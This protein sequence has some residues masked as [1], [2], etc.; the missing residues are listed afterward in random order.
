[1]KRGV[2]PAHPIRRPGVWSEFVAF[3]KKQTFVNLPPWTNRPVLAILQ[4]ALMGQRGDLTSAKNLE[5][6]SFSGS[7]DL[8][9]THIIY[10]YIYIYPDGF[11]VRFRPLSFCMLL[12]ELPRLPLFRAMFHVS[13]N[14]HV[15][16]KV[17]IA[18]IFLKCKASFFWWRSLLMAKKDDGLGM[19]VGG[20]DDVCCCDCHERWYLGD[21]MTFVVHG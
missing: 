4:Q 1:M 17:Q 21:M 19:G 18:R 8:K 6:Y 9:N 2:S 3:L 5:C 20:D 13:F 16:S 10:I 7:A 11:A 14:E 12:C 15:A